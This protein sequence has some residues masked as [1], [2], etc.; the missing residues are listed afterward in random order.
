[1][2]SQW[3][4]IRA[5]LETALRRDILRGAI[6]VSLIVGS[7]L[8]VINQGERITAG[9][10][11]SLPHFFLNYLVPYLVASWSGARAAVRR[12]GTD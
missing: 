5:I 10:G 1:V 9:T 11:L 4:A 7:V 6:A 8:N 12:N 3:Q 2:T